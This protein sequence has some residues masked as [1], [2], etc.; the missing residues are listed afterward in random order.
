[1]LL[2]P[3]RDLSRAVRKISR[4]VDFING[5]SFEAEHHKKEQSLIR[6]AYFLSRYP[7]CTIQT[8]TIPIE[9][10]KVK[11]KICKTSLANQ[12]FQSIYFKKME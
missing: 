5:C 12:N 2:N 1:M 8:L 9:E 11:T 4:H 10:W 6:P 3:P 7:I